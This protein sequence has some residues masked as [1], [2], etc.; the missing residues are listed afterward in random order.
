M[1]IVWFYC[2]LF[3]LIF[4]SSCTSPDDQQKSQSNDP[5]IVLHTN[6][7]NITL[8]L[9]E[10]TPIHRENFLKL[11][12]Q[13]FFDSLTFHR[14]IHN[15]VVQSGDPRSR[16]STWE[17]S[18]MG[19]GYDIPAEFTEHHV[20]VR[21]ALAMARKPDDE[22]PLRVSSGSQFYFVTGKPASEALLD[23]METNAT[24]MRKGKAFLQYQAELD[25][26]RFSGTFKEYMALHPV[27]PFR[28]SPTQ[29]DTYLQ[30]GGD[31]RLDF[32]YTV[33]GEVVEGIDV[34]LKVSRQQVDANHM[35]L[36]DMRIDSVTILP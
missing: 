16:Y 36:I 3:S 10:D 11:A 1:R 4:L 19:P 15:F 24:G 9:Y 30:I 33:F 8:H 18:V 5:Q 34:V 29:R 35:P 7:G 28:Y 27:K 32:S 25:S 12:K 20:H 2:S 17:D 31:P 23:S 6:M 21:G 22:N 13:G 14:V 26:S